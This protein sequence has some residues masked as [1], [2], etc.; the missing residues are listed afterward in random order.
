MGTAVVGVPNPLSQ[1]LGGSLS[2]GG[3]AASHILIGKS[4]LDLAFQKTGKIPV[5]NHTK[6]LTLVI[7]PN[8]TF[9]SCL[10]KLR[11]MRLLCVCL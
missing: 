10:Y 8:S 5:L 11:N 9:H 2:N 3:A 1:V 7:N 6:C 4:V